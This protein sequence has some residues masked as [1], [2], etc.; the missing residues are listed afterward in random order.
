MKIQVQELNDQLAA[1][2]ND[3]VIIQKIE[4]PADKK[5]ITE[6]EEQIRELKSE[7]AESKKVQRHKK[8][9]NNTGSKT[10]DKIT[11]TK[12]TS[13]AESGYDATKEYYKEILQRIKEG[14]TVGRPVTE[15]ECTLCNYEFDF[16]PT[17]EWPCP[18]NIKHVFCS[19]CT[20][21]WENQ[22]PGGTT[23]CPLCQAPK[24]KNDKEFPRLP[25]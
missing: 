21:E 23:P 20:K 7:Q 8:N 4:D 11:Q 10:I 14:L 25:K 3:K 12:I 17:E 1:S 2:R 15:G 9:N 5:K 22:N 24:R 6:L 16:L 19:V 18:G 13:D